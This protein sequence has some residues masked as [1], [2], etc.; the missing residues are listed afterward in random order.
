MPEQLT[1]GEWR[2]VWGHGLLGLKCTSDSLLLIVPQHLGSLF[3]QQGDTSRCLFADG[4]MVEVPPSCLPHLPASPETIESPPPPTDQDNL[5][6]ELSGS[7]FKVRHRLTG[8]NLELVRY[9]KSIRLQHPR[10]GDVMASA[11]S[12][13]P[14]DG[15]AMAPAPTSGVLVTSAKERSHQTGSTLSPPAAASL[16]ADHWSHQIHDPGVLPVLLHLEKFGSVTESDIENL[17]NSPRQAR[18]FSAKLDEYRPILPFY[19][20]TDT[21]SGLK[22]YRKK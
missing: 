22:T 3:L 10:L 4:S 14:Y 16:P 8:L 18:A 7:H 11:Q 15:S 13:L 21:Q 12:I 6:W 20:E 9:G 5:V 2:L 19:V 1:W 17:T